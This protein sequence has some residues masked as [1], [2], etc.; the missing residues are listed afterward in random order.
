MNGARDQTAETVVSSVISKK[1]DD[2][3]PQ[4][5]SSPISVSALLLVPAARPGLPGDDEVD[6]RGCGGTGVGSAVGEAAVGAG[7]DGAS[8][9]GSCGGAVSVGAWSVNLDVRVGNGLIAA[10]DSACDA[11]AGNR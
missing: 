5:P 9:Q 2:R 11:L 7:R 8:E 1:L 10:V 4:A 3:S 6:R